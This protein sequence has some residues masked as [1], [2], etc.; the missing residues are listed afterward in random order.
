MLYALIGKSGA[1]KDVLKSALVERDNFIHITTTTSRPVREGE[2]EGRE[3]HFISEKEFLNKIENNEFAEYR[4]YNTVFGTW[5]Y[6]SP[7]CEIDKNK[8]YVIILTVD[9]VKKF[10]EAYKD[11][12]TKVIYIEAPDSIREERAKLRDKNFNKDEWERRLIDDAK[13][14]APEI[15]DEFA[16]IKLLNNGDIDDLYNAF[17]ESV[18]EHDTSWIN[19]VDDNFGL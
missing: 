10:T 7:R 2:V 4:A 11:T 17:H 19:E 12:P 15:V 5:Y 18:K 13:V 14:F 6:G 8:D 9:G 1:G 3:Y 16:D